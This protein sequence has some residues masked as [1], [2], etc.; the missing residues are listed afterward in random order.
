[1]TVR[2]YRI[3]AN[4]NFSIVDTERVNVVD[5]AQR[6]KVPRKWLRAQKSTNDPTGAAQRV[7][8]SLFREPPLRL[9]DLLS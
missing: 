6:L 7:D 8:L 1:V 4:S 3:D 5:R 9:A 2:Q